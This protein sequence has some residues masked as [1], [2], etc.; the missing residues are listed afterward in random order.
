MCSMP[1]SGLGTWMHD[2]RSIKAWSIS[3]IDVQ[4]KPTL[5]QF[6]DLHLQPAA[7]WRRKERIE[8]TTNL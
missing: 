3:R 1:T 8:E 4:F 2:G 6:V 7:L 5:H